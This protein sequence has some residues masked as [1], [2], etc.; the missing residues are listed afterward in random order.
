[1]KHYLWKRWS[2]L[3]LYLI[4]ALQAALVVGEQSELLGERLTRLE[5][6][7]ELATVTA[8]EAGTVRDAFITVPAIQFLVSFGTL[9]TTPK[10]AR[11]CANGCGALAAAPIPHGATIVGLEVDACDDNGAGSGVIV[12]TVKRIPGNESAAAPELLKLLQVNDA[13]CSY[14]FAPLD[15]PH[16][17]DQYLD[18]YYV[19][20]QGTGGSSERFQ[21]IRVYYRSGD[22]EVVP[23]GTQ[24]SLS[25]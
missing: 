14:R 8:F 7:E 6:E 11:H 1:M 18:S 16:V 12:V 10:L 2:S 22:G 20:F 5:V 25:P 4:I 23:T 13:G 21:A 19:N 15:V 9:E 17:V 3:P 24:N